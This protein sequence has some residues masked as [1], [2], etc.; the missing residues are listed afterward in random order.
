MNLFKRI[1][2]YFD[3]KSILF[4]KMCLNGILVLA[5]AG[6]CFGVYL[7]KTNNYIIFIGSL[8]VI[9]INAATAISIIFAMLR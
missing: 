2:E 3:K 4:I 1:D 9:M 5:I 7:M 6:I 8:F